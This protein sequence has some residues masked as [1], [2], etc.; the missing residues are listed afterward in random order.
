MNKDLFESLLSILCGIYPEGELLDIWSFYLIKIV[1]SILRYGQR[2][3]EACITESGDLLG[4]NCPLSLAYLPLQP[5][6]AHEVG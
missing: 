4:A 3:C 2:T 5:L 6:Q 1:R